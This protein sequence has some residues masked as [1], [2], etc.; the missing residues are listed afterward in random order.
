MLIHAPE[1]LRRPFR[2]RVHVMTGG[3]APPSAVISRMEALGFEVHHLY[4]L[5]E[6]YGPAAVCAWQP[7]LAEL[8]LEE[9]AA[10]I[11]RQ[12]VPHRMVGD[13]AVL[14]PATMQKV[15]ADGA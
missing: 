15:P 10:F 9:R 14:D 4:G 2:Q 13:L 12:G 6:T 11:S 1:S 7:G 5:T 8:P 3:A